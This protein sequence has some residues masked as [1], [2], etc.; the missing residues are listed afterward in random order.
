MLSPQHN[1]FGHGMSLFKTAPI[2]I[3]KHKKN[4]EEIKKKGKTT[5]VMGINLIP[6]I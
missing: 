3:L 5:H 4:L 2:F 6:V 1:A